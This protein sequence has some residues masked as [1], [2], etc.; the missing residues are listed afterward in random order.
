MSAKGKH[1]VDTLLPQVPQE[2][3]DPLR[4]VIDRVAVSAIDPARLE[5]RIERSYPANAAYLDIVSKRI[6]S[7]SRELPPESS[8]TDGPGQDYLSFWFSHYK[9]PLLSLVNALFSIPNLPGSF[10]RPIKFSLQRP[11][12]SS[13]SSLSSGEV[14]DVDDRKDRGTKKRQREE[15]DG[16]DDSDSDSESG[17]SDD[18]SAISVSDGSSESDEEAISV[19][20]ENDGDVVEIVDDVDLG[21]A[22]QEATDV[23]VEL[24]DLPTIPRLDLS[25]EME[26]E[27]A[28]TKEEV[29]IRRQSLGAPAPAAPPTKSPPTA[30]PATPIA[31]MPASRPT[32][33][34]APSVTPSASASST[35]PPKQEPLRVIPPATGEFAEI[36]N[37]V[38]QRLKLLHDIAILDQSLGGHSQNL[39]FQRSEFFGD[40]VLE[41]YVTITLFRTKT[42]APGSLLTATRTFMVTNRNLSDVFDILRLKYMLPWKSFD[43]HDYKQ[44]ADVVEAIIC[45]L[46]S[47]LSDAARTPTEIRLIEETRDILVSFIMYIGER[48]LYRVGLPRGPS[49]H[50]GAA[51]ARPPITKRQKQYEERQRKAQE[52]K[53]RREAREAK[54]QAMLAQK[55]SQLHRPDASAAAGPNGVALYPESL[56]PQLIKAYEMATPAG[57]DRSVPYRF[58]R[59]P[60]FPPPPNIQKLSHRQIKMLHNAA[61]RAGKAVQYAGFLKNSEDYPPL[62]FLDPIVNEWGSQYSDTMSDLAKKVVSS[63]KA[64]KSPPPASSSSSSNPPPSA[65]RTPSAQPQQLNREKS[66]KPAS[67]QTTKSPRSP[68]PRPLKMQKREEPRRASPD[69][70]E[71]NLDFQSIFMSTSVA[72]VLAHS[73][74]VNHLSEEIRQKP[75]QRLN[76]VKNSTSPTPV[77][78]PPEL[79]DILGPNILR[80]P[81]SLGATPIPQQQAPK[82]P[83]KLNPTRKSGSK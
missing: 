22:H 18:D 16:D 55:I 39:A 6:Q 42:F 26:Q 53:I 1:F 24:P 66:S 4:R 45:E 14:I 80:F 43:E 17:S 61:I 31:P 73:S 77:Q 78:P 81:T 41:Y 62:H 32:S 9:T 76:V 65:A 75:Q 10:Q 20:D 38:L 56:T 57:W 23:D 70:V 64:L 11:P 15:R 25:M 54:K 35:T 2:L 49:N 8:G 12:S 7:L 29:R 13:S 72:P 67:K 3:L 71:R 47:R 33:T 69:D 83:P 48:N 59:S 68:S 74:S 21:G 63:Q 79:M 5:A 40:S 44:K 28:Q 27:I 36:S 46:D 19:D 50:R 58:Y 34:P 82:A 51:F 37:Q 52:R 60:P 30:T